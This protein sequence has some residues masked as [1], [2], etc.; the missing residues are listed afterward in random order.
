M[1]AYA[2]A[3]ILYDTGRV[4]RTYPPDREVAASMQL[5]ASLALLFWYV[6]R[7]LSDR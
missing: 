1:I 2:G 7:L 3:A 4:L 5:F 6:L